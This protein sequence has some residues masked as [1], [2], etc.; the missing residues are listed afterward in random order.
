LYYPVILHLVRLCDGTT[1]YILSSFINDITGTYVLV[2]S[3][4]VTSPDDE[5]DVVQSRPVPIYAQ[6]FDYQANGNI[7]YTE[8]QVTNNSVKYYQFLYDDINRLNRAEYGQKYLIEEV[9]DDYISHFIVDDNNDRYTMTANYD[10]LGDIQTITRKG[11]IP[12]VE[13]CLIPADIDNLAYS[14]GGGQLLKV[15][16]SAPTPGKSYGF[17]QA[18]ASSQV[19]YDYDDNGNLIYDPYKSL[20]ISYNFLNLPDTV[21]SGATIVSRIVYDANGTKW[22][23]ISNGEV[24]EY[25]N[26]IEYIDDTLHLIMHSEG[27]MIPAPSPTEEGRVEYWLKDH[28]GNTRVAIADLNQDGAITLE[29]DPSIPGNESE[30]MQENHYYPFGMDQLGNWAP[31]VGPENDYLYN[32]KEL[33]D[34]LGWYYYGFRMFDPAIARFTGVDPIA[35]QFPHVSVFNYAEN[36]PVGH[37]DLHGLQQ[38]DPELSPRKTHVRAKFS[39]ELNQGVYGA[40]L[41]AL[42]AKEGVVA[43]IDAHKLLAVDASLGS[44]GFKR[45]AYSTYGKEHTLGISGGHVIGGGFET[46]HMDGE[47]ENTTTV[48]LNAAIGYSQLEISNGELISETKGIQI[49]A[50]GG[51]ALL[52]F[53]VNLALEIQT[54]NPNAPPT[55]EGMEKIQKQSEEQRNSIQQD[56]TRVNKVYLLGG[57]L[58]IAGEEIKPQ[59]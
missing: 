35:D 9:N 29:D 42:G 43:K 20:S 37:I 7:D 18:G 19:E 14:Y 54:T 36:E 45:D 16:D 31:M 32:G 15:I 1:T 12:G 10:L 26:G 27:R 52:G 56:N 33:D 21:S 23:K 50:T 13:N 48:E 8:W 3:I 6:H 30:L 53:N 38:E 4:A 40:E 24:H 2:D 25:F 39:F 5:F 59:N 57:E 41:R 58:K 17:D 46:T 55:Y 11:M 51:I 28:L 34:N 44:D 47:S 49:G 22:K